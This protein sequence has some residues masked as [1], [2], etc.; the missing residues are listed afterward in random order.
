MVIEVG[1]TKGEEEVFDG[2]HDF[3]SG[4]KVVYID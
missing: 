1:K 2:K 4:L 3:V